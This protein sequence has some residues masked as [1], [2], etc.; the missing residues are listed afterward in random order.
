MGKGRHRRRDRARQ[1]GLRSRRLIAWVD[2]RTSI[3]HL[4]T[5]EAAAAGRLGGGRYITLCGANV[6]PASLVD[7]GE[8]YCRAC[9]SSIDIPPSARTTRRW[10]R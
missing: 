1:T 9:R 2:A 10:F 5:P 6:L 3:T 4:L 8:S 7:P